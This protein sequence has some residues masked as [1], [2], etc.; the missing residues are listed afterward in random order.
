MK[1]PTL[2]SIM[3]PTASGKTSLSISVAKALNTEI[4]SCDSRQFYR[5]LA[6]GSA[7]P[8][9]K[10]L[11]EVPHHFIADRSVT[12]ELSAGEYA[13]EARQVLQRV[14]SEHNEKAILVG[15]SGLYADGIMYGF[16]SM[17]TIPVNIREELNS[18]W[19]EEGLAP[20]V[21]ELTLADPE[22]SA[23]ADLKNPVRVIRALEVIRHT[24][25]SF[26]SFRKQHL[27]SRK[28]LYHLEKVALDWPREELYERI[29]QRVDHMMTAGLLEEVQGLLPHQHLQSLNTVGYVELF[30]YINGD[31]SL[32]FAVEEIKKNTRRFAKRQLTWLRKD[33][34]ILWIPAMENAFEIAKKHFKWE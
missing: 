20:L 11:K 12:S 22:F 17:P 6:I 8:S 15:G 28:G 29:N 21:N 3:G 13:Q 24:G 1:A 31:I 19:Q 9:P 33:P 34:E 32:E 23:K 25:S 5:E 2:I 30:S 16:D 14:F 27:T 7:P 10:E 26:S 4:I 18:Q